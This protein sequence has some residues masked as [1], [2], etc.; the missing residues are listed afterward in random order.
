MKYLLILPFFLL[1][2]TAKAQFAEPCTEIPPLNQEV[3]NVL[4]PYM[5]RK[6]DRGE[7][8]DAAKLALNKVKAD[9]DGLYA[10]GRVIDPKKECIQP[11]DIVQFEKA[12]FKI[13]T[14]NGS[15]SETF[16]HHTAIVYKVNGPGDLQLLHQNTGQNGKKMGVTS[17]NLKF[18]TKGKITIYRPVPK[19]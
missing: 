4:E 18:K 9:W 3:L 2:F 12:E 16:G 5:G 14:E 1:I 7:C 11:G 6:L 10:F 17:L 13:E 8:W 19:A 15:Y